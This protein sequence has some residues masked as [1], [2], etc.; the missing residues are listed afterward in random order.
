M[1]AEEKTNSNKKTARIADSSKRKAVTVLRVLYPIWMVLGLFG[2]MYVPATVIVAGDAMAT[3]NNILANELL[4]RMGIV[5][6]LSVQVIQIFVVLLLYKLF[7]SVNKNYASFMVVF[8]LVGIPIAMLNTLNRLATLL[9]LNGA[10]YLK[11]FEAGQLHAL[12]MLFLNLNEQGQ[13]IAT[14]FWGLWLFPLGYLIYKSGYFPKVL[15]AWVMMGCVGYVL[16]SFTHFIL[17]NY[18]NYEAI[19]T[20]LVLLLTLGEILFALW[21]MLKGAKIPEMKS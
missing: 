6:S 17:P 4:F 15:G 16:D 11:V 12:V 9:L 7:K 1:T 20:P 21:V 8:A 14:I 3:A 2:V 5:G 10:D 13:L 18:A 19:L